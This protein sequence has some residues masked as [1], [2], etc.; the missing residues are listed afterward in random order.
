M[1]NQLLKLNGTRAGIPVD[2]S[3]EEDSSRIVQEEATKQRTFREFHNSENCESFEA[4]GEENMKKERLSV[5]NISSSLERSFDD[6]I[7][8]VGEKRK[9]AHFQ[10]STGSNIN[11]MQENNSQPQENLDDTHIAKKDKHQNDESLV[12]IEKE[13]IDT[14]INAHD[15]NPL[16]DDPQQTNNATDNQI[17]QK[18]VNEDVNPKEEHKIHLMENFSAN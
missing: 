8:M 14:I 15:G 10:Q 16:I 18:I 17:L 5:E 1:G 7:C 11:Q 12:V 6:S 9:L 4:I 13:S 3:C 2:M